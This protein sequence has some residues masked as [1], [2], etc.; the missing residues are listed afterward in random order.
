MLPPNR[1]ARQILPYFCTFCVVWWFWRVF[2]LKK[3]LGF[4][5]LTSGPSFANHRGR[6]GWLEQRRAGARDQ[7]GGMRLPGRPVVFGPG[8]RATGVRGTGS[9]T[10]FSMMRRHTNETLAQAGLGVVAHQRL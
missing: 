9:Q 7:S 5:I 1:E 3:K 10:V 2:G 4:R 8:V 6:D